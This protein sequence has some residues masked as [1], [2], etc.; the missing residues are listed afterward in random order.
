MFE[1][2]KEI[3]SKF[4][5]KIITPESSLE[6]DL[7]LSSLEVVEIVCEFEET[8]DIEINDRDIRKFVLVK[9]IIDYLRNND[10]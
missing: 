5:D 3:L 1:K 10:V 9:D 4:T 2:V 7:G 6:S 8:F